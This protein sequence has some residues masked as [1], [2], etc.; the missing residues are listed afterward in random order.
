MYYC[1]KIAKYRQQLPKIC[2]FHLYLVDFVTIIQL[3]AETNIIFEIS[4]KNWVDL[5][6]FQS[7]LASFVFFEKIHP[8]SPSGKRQKVNSLEYHFD[9]VKQAPNYEKAGKT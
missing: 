7:V 9:C 4:V 2:I 3:S 6:I 1:I 5:S 8:G